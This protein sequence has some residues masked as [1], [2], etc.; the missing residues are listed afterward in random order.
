VEQVKV[1]LKL[2]NISPNKVATYDLL[3][4]FVCFLPYLFFSSGLASFLGLPSVEVASFLGLP[5]V[6]VAPF[7]SLVALVALVTLELE[8]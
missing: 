5:S 6:E 4:F 3:F 7:T 8:A 2:G 1:S